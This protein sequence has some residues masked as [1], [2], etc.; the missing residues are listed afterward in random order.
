MQGNIIFPPRLNLSSEKLDRGAIFL[1]ENGLEIFIF[2]GRNTSPQM[3]VGIFGQSSL[4][5]IPVG[6]VKI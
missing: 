5:Q 4:D 3:L 6:K 1:I 2:V